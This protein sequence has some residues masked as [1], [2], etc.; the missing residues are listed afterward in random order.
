[1]ITMIIG[2]DPDIHK[3]GYCVIRGKKVEEVTCLPFP[4][5]VERLMDVRESGENPLIVVE[6]GWLNKTLWHFAYTKGARVSGNIGKRIG[7]NHQTGKHI[8]E[9]CEFWGMN[10][11][12][13]K[14]LG[15][16]WKGR[17]GKIT[18]E[19]LQSILRSNGY[20]DLPRKVTNQDER[21]SVL[22]AIA[23]D[24]MGY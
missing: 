6:G 24:N 11:R 22:L 7:A 17:D 2:I 4:S 5:L 15:K 10:V 18:H 1:M 19:E 9:M 12:V 16:R 3:S 14:P 23:G 20:S 21:D 8:V 13:Q